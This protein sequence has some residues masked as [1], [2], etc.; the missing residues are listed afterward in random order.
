MLQS[1]FMKPQFYTLILI[2]AVTLLSCDQSLPRTD[3]AAPSSTLPQVA[4]NISLPAGTPAGVAA[5]PTASAKL[6]PAHGSPGHR[7]DIAVGAPLDGTPAFKTSLP[8]SA[9]SGP[10]VQPLSVPPGAGLPAIAPVNNTPVVNTVPALPAGSANA[11]AALNPAHGLPGHRC[12]IAVGAPLNSPPGKTATATAPTVATPVPAT[13]AKAGLNPKH[14]EP[15]HRCDI[16]VGAPLNSPVA[17]TNQAAVNTTPSPVTVSPV[18]STVAANGTAV[19]ADG[20]NPKHGEPG[21]RCDI[22]VGAPLTPKK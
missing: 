17:K 6:N 9:V 11:N 3:A 22:A 1:A 19:P 2:S 10:P 12:D 14:G 8:A 4:G 21:H 13:T 16:A 15:G 5:M 7:C 18:A 20:L